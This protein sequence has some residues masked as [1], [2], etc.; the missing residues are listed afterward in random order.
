[1]A[2]NFSFRDFGIGLAAGWASAFILYQMRGVLGRTRDD[3]RASAPK[4]VM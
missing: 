1:M 2:D 3:V 4:G